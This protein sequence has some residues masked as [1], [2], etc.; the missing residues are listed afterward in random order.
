[1]RRARFIIPAILALVAIFAAVTTA[2]FTDD[3]SANNGVKYEFHIGDTFFGPTC[4]PPG[5]GAPACPAVAGAEGGDTIE[6]TGRGT[7]GRPGHVTGMGTFVHNIVDSSSPGFPMVSGTWRATELLSFKPYGRNANGPFPKEFRA[8]EARIRVELFVG[9]SW[10]GDATLTI[11]CILGPPRSYPRGAF[12]GVRL[13]VDGGPNFDMN[14]L[15]ATI[16]IKQ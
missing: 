15:G 2:F 5:S 9:S 8:G 1:M 3:A 13:N 6:I 10:V 11:G 4:P 7:I 14:E 12:E 16:F